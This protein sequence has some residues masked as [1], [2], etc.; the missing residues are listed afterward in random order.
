LIQF[1]GFENN[2]TTTIISRRRRSTIVDLIIATSASDLSIAAT[3]IH[4][5]SFDIFGDS[6]EV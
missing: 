3:I 5:Y 1:I 2:V 4:A 6:V